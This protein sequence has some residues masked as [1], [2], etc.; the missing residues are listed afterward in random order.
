MALPHVGGLGDERPA[1][2]EVRKIVSS[3]DKLMKEKYPTGFASIEPISFKTQLVAGT[4]YFVRVSSVGVD[5]DD[6]QL[7]GL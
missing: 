1:D 6:S 3:V 7:D 4:N 2:E 5:S